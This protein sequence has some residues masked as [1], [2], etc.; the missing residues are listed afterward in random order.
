MRKHFLLLFLMALLPLAGWADT[1]TEPTA[2]TGLYYKAS[3][4]QQLVASVEV[5]GK[6]FYYAVVADG[7]DKPTVASAY[8]TTVPT[9][10]NAGDYDVYWFSISTGATPQASDITGAAK[11]DVNIAPLK[12]QIKVKDPDPQIY[13]TDYATLADGTSFYEDKNA[14]GSPAAGYVKLTALPEGVKATI[15]PTFKDWP[16]T[17][18]VKYDGTNVDSYEFA[19]EGYTNN[20]NYAVVI[21]DSES[22]GKIK[23]SPKALTIKTAWDDETKTTAEYGEALPGWHASYTGLIDAENEGTTAAPAPKAEVLG[24]TLDYTVKT[25]GLVNYWATGTFNEHGDVVGDADNYTVTP[26]GLTSKN[27]TITFE[28]VILQVKPKALAASMIQAISSR[29]YDGTDQKAKPAEV[30]VKLGD[31]TLVQGTD[32]TFVTTKSNGEALGATGA[33]NAGTYKVTI[34]GNRNYSGDVSTNLVIAQ[35]ALAIVTEDGNSTY[36]DD[37][38]TV[39]NNVSTKFSFKNLVEGDEENGAP[40]SGVLNDGVKFKAVMTGKD[41]G[42]YEI[43]AKAYKMVGD[44]ATEQAVTDDAIAANYIATYVNEGKWTIKPFGVTYK[45]KEQSV[46]NGRANELVDAG[47]A[48]LQITAAN[49][50]KYFED[51]PALK[52]SDMIATYPKIKYNSATKKIEAVSGSSFTYQRNTAAAGADPVYEDI[53]HNYS[54]TITPKTATVLTG[55]LIVNVKDKTAKYG[56]KAETLTVT[57][58][59]GTTAVN[60]AAKEYFE[61]KLVRAK[62]GKRGTGANAVDVE[63]PNAGVYTITAEEYDAT[64]FAGYTITILDGKYTIEQR[65]LKTITANAQTLTVTKAK[66]A[67]ILKNLAAP[68]ATTVEFALKD[69]DYSLTDND[70]RLLYKEIASATKSGYT[71]PVGA[72]TYEKV[73]EVK[74]KDAGL[75]NFKVGTDWMKAGNLTVIA[76]AAEVTVDRNQVDDADTDEDEGFF[77]T[78]IAPNNGKVGTIKFTNE[79]LLKPQVWT[80]MV[81]PFDITVAKLSAAL[82][83]AVVN[84]LAADATAENVKFELNMGTLAANTPFLVKTS[85]EVDMNNVVFEEVV[86]KAPATAD[87]AVV[88]NDAVKFHGVYDEITRAFTANEWITANNKW[89]G[90]YKHGMKP[91]AAYVEIIGSNNAPVFTVQDENGYTTA[92]SAIKA[93]GTA[94]EADG[95]YTLNGVKLQG[96]PVEKGVYVR[97]GKK[98]V[99]K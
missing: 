36:G 8:T 77:A 88:G 45:L 4:S 33:V 83:Y 80:A 44:P 85:E 81:L 37:A 38:T 60:D 27:Y 2:K 24:G 97:N 16:T 1:G 53:T 93:D 21:L 86:I 61:T 13:G 76:D 43:T 67:N 46:T 94:L 18:P 90:S 87:A 42:K 31:K 55:Q 40:K 98:V 11:I 82:G 64:K 12:I 84:T 78:Y 71:D 92:I 57:V 5:T 35:R 17:K 39:A 89:W 56:G 29:V 28:P 72:G 79:R 10:T 69:T 50:S 23:I 32:Y 51:A 74:I 59:G 63:Y 34:S 95:W 62:E 41:E 96:A 25:P 48:G 52:N 19:I 20:S 47:D 6:A 99:I 7:V 14:S 30:V 66:T 58:S 65:E 73:I 22:K 54:V 9:G 91:L 3:E 15:E 26:T 49:Y 75:T 70:R 68:S